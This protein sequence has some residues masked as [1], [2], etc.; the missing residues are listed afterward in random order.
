M[1]ALFP[2]TL[3]G[4]AKQALLQLR[5]AWHALTLDDRTAY[6][7]RATDL[8]DLERRMR[9]WDQRNGRA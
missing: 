9:A 4:R 2:S 5:T 6:L 3:A 8:P 7:A 1:N